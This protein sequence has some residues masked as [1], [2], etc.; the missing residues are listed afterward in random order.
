MVPAGVEKLNEILQEIN[1][2]YALEQT[3]A[4]RDKIWNKPKA[5]MAEEY[6][7]TKSKILY[8]IAGSLTKQVDVSGGSFNARGFKNLDTGKTI[9]LYEDIKYENNT[10]AIENTGI[11]IAALTEDA[12]SECCI[13]V[14]EKNEAVYICA[15][16]KNRCEHEIN[17]L[18]RVVMNKC[19][20]WN[21]ARES[22]KVYKTNVPK[23]T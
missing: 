15:T 17:K 22:F 20:G 21:K 6:S 14:I 4:I 18:A 11:D 7:A 5:P 9:M 3:G 23:V 16:T 2:K 8:T 10:C 19:N 13:K 1:D 12:K